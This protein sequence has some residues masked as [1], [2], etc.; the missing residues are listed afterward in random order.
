MR[1]P[2][3]RRLIP[4]IAA[5]AAL[6]LT[7]RYGAFPGPGDVPVLD[8]IALED[9][10]AYRVIRAWYYLAPACVTLSLGSIIVR[11][12][13]ALRRAAGRAAAF[14]AD[15]WAGAAA[16]AD[17]L[18]SWRFV[19]AFLLAVLVLAWSAAT[20]P[21]PAP[22]DVPILDLI[23]FEDPGFYAVIR[24]WHLV[25]PSVMAFMG[26]M[27]VTSSYR[28]W[29]G[30]RTRDRRFG[31]GALPRW[32]TSPDDDSPALVV[33]EVHHPTEP[34]EITRPAWLTLPERGLYTGVAI[35]GAVGTGKTSACMRPFAQQL[36]S[37]QSA[38]P[39]KRAAA[40]VLEV[41]GDF[42]HDIRAV[43]EDAG[44]GDDYT[45]LALGGRWQWNP[46]ASAMDSYSLAYTV[47]SLLNQLFGKSK[48]PFWQQAY[49]NLIRWLI[50][51]HRALPDQ[52]V[53][54]RDLYHCAIDP[55]LIAH[56]IGQAHALSGPPPASYIVAPNV[57][58]LAHE[59]KGLLLNHTWQPADDGGPAG[60]VRTP[61]AE[62][63]LDTL[64]SLGIQATVQEDSRPP[65][66]HA[67]R[68]AAIARWYQYDWLQLDPKLRTSIVEGVSVFLSMF[69]LPDVARVFCPPAPRR[70]APVPVDL[71]QP[72]T[73]V[74]PTVVSGLLRPL[75]PLHRLIESGKVIALNMP[76]G[77]NPALARTIGV[78]LKNTWLQTLLTR[79]AAIK[80]NPNRYFRPAVFLC[81]EYQSFASVGE[82]DPAGDEKAF[83][84]TRQC[85][86]IPIV[87]T[88]SISSL[89]SVLSGQDAWRTLLQTLRTKVFLSLSDDS[90]AELAS[91]MC[92]KVLR[93]SPSYSFTE[94]AKP[95]F[96]V[97]TA[98]AGGAK[99]TLGTSKSYREQ[100]E[101]L[102]HPRTFSL[103]ENCQAIVLPYDGTNA[104][105]ATRVYLKP[106]YLPRDR[107]YWRARESGQL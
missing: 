51:L 24:T 21:F 48:E 63:L 39:Q 54:F 93:L 68:V 49:T 105:P 6:Y 1:A 23:A 22:G 26:V 106:H 59:D 57:E 64:T 79:P 38:D 56:K 87:A 78:M 85:R 18:L 55:K 82:D 107:P 12:A 84:L 19:A 76:A 101:P 89:K 92:G 34:R 31:R 103:L 67:Q 45:E 58:I 50:E 62:D 35:F 29:F 13:A 37:W 9:P 94:S 60:R 104:Q 20:R 17:R 98:R 41:K 97:I 27:V 99:G 81:D 69:D 74:A 25:M 8:L 61:Y 32:P 80:T 71:P 65:S 53:T 83:A 3:T 72:P 2:P 11:H 44:R 47:A 90:S 43:L 77:A 15:H 95:G 88:Q 16:T 100:R 28:L 46:L 4:V 7:L 33:G 75:P 5:L 40:L 86:V 73:G 66:E 42:C 52:W 91:N 10:L 30:S 102:F 96:S 14:A 70:A 36:L